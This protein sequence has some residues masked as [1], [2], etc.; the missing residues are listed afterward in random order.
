MGNA[1]VKEFQEAELQEATIAE[2]KCISADLISSEILTILAKTKTM[3]KTTSYETEE[4][5]VY[6]TSKATT[7]GGK[8]TFSDADGKVVAVVKV[9]QG[10]KTDTSSIFR[11]K[12]S[13]EDQASIAEKE[14][15]DGEALYLFATIETKKGMA[16]ATSTY[17]I[18]TGE[19]DG[20]P[21]LET[22]LIG[23]KLKAMAFYAEVRTVDEL[24]IAKSC[25]AGGM[26]GKVE[27]SAGVDLL[28]VAIVAQSVA[29][30]GAGSA[31]AL[32]GSI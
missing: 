1:A 6:A 24:L 18:V 22:V 3:A 32:A 16:T 8:N 7:F 11:T 25:V 31:G 23:K 26:T 29:P 10:L 17:S 12:P 20:E 30:G 2:E 14:T 15:D 19:A 4:G 13:Y 5:K 21:V 27:M 28:A 9:K